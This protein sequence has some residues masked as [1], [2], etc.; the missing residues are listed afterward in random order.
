MHTTKHVHMYWTVSVS[1]LGLFLAP[2]IHRAVIPHSLFPLSVNLPVFSS[3]VA[4]LIPLSSPPYGH[5]S[6]IWSCE[7]CCVTGSVCQKEYR[8]CSLLSK[9][10]HPPPLGSPLHLCPI[11]IFSIPY[12]LSFLSRQLLLPL[13]TLAHLFLFCSQFLLI[14][15]IFH[16]PHKSL[17][18]PA[19]QSQVIRHK[20]Y[21]T[22][23]SH[24]PNSHELQVEYKHIFM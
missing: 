6:V 15:Y 9:S 14:S 18:K 7:L 11:S 3:L 4:R 1:L 8:D 21:L 2:A 24:S 22:E 16:T 23:H 20:I 10:T 12:S 13:H 19:V 17:I 5:C